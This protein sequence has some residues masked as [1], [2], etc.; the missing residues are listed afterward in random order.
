MSTRKFES[1]EEMKTFHKNVNWDVWDVRYD[2]LRWWCFSLK[3]TPTRKAFFQFI[4]SSVV[5]QLVWDHKDYDL[6]D[7]C[8]ENTLSKV[9]GEWA[10]GCVYMRLRV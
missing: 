4:R 6:V 1:I 5:Y 2:N 9:L 8:D 3:T 10:E 7:Q